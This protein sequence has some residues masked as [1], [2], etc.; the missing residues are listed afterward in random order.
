MIGLA[1]KP[2]RLRRAKEPKLWTYDELV[3]NFPEANVPVELWNGE[4][5]MPPTPDASHQES[6]FDFACALRAWVGGPAL[7]KVF[8]APLDMV[9]APRQVTQPDVM[10]VAKERLQIV[11]RVIHGPVDLAVEVISD[12]SHDRDRIKKRDLYEQHG[13]KEYW[14]LDRDA[15]TIEVLFLAAGQYKLI[16]RWRHGETARSKL[17]AGFEVKVSDVLHGSLG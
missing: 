7:G 14:I 16:G 1:S 11:K 6:T 3:A 13:V 17:L 2:P 5:I 12:Y 4:I 9:L 8:I 10:F 15:G